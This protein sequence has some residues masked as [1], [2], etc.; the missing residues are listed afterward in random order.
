MWL[1]DRCPTW[2]EMVELNNLLFVPEE[3]TFQVHPKKVDYVNAHPTAL[4]IWKPA[5][6]PMSYMMLQE[7]KFCVQQVL[8]GFEGKTIP[9]KR[10]VSHGVFFGKR[11]ISIWGGDNWPTWEEVC[12]IK[13]NEF[14]EDVAALQFHI[15]RKLD[16]N[17]ERV[18][19]LWHTDDLQ[20]IT[21]PPKEFV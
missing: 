8:A 18:L 10:T 7:M 6:D 3:P 9:S 17:K 11:Y 14:G 2:P 13:K 15:S 20:A 21:L 1:E 19:L 4:H 16:L 12:Q 5:N